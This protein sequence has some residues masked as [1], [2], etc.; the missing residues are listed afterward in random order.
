MPVC[1][2]TRSARPQSVDGTGLSAIL[3]AVEQRTGPVVPPIP[4]AGT[5]PSYVPG[6]TPPSRPAG[7][8]DPALGQVA[9]LPRRP[10]AE[11]VSEEAAPAAAS[12]ADATADAAV[13]EPDGSDDDAEPDGR[14]E[15][16]GGPVFEVSD[17]RSSILADHYGI[18][19]RLDA[20]EAEFRWDEIGAVEID[21]PRFGRRFA[22]TVYTSSRRWYEGDVEAPSRSVLKT[23]TAE[24]DTVLDAR[25]SDEKSADS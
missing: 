3:P 15:A 6:I 1:V 11:K 12:A 9:D 22:V 25:F 19:L 14:G 10:A 23:W 2:F 17:R 20:E 5:N 24:L 7:A 18:T 4:A 13:K 8:P 21:T 16:D